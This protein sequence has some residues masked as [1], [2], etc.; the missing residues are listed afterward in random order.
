MDA[1]SG[2]II[3]LQPFFRGS[4]T[5][6]SASGSRRL[7]TVAPYGTMLPKKARVLHDET[8]PALLKIQ[9]RTHDGKQATTAGACR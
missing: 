8:P 1:Q 5:A 7:Q 6:Q 3:Y 4:L 9:R 2:R